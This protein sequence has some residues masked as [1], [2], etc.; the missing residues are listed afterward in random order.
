MQNHYKCSVPT[1]L[2]MPDVSVMYAASVQLDEGC[3]AATLLHDREKDVMPKF[4]PINVEGVG[5][6]DIWGERKD[7]S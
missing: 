2:N 3:P 1:A 6:K 5:K 7:V 4:Q